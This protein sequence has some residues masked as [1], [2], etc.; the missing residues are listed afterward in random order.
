MM[1]R[2][3][4][5]LAFAA[6]PAFADD[7]DAAALQLAD[8]VQAEPVQASDW[9][10]FVEIAGG[11]STLRNGTQGGGHADNQRLSL[12]V[13]LD[14]RLARAWRL[15]FADRLDMN[16]HNEPVR[17][18][19]I[20]TLK[21]AYLGWQARDDLLFDLGRINVRNGVA[22][23]YNPTDYFRAGAVRS[24]VS[25]DPGSLKRNR[26]GSV[27]LRAQ[28]LWDSGSLSAAY[29]PKLS[30]HGSDAALNPNVG[31]TNNRDRWL[32]TFSQKLSKNVSPQW[33]L[34]K[35]ERQPVQAGFNLALLA[36]DATVVFM[37]WSGGRS[38]SL[39]SQA[40]A[41]ADDTAFR[42]RAST[43][44]TYTTP[45]KLSLTLEYEYNGAG[46]RDS[47]WNVLPRTS[48][49]AYGLYRAA[50]Q[51][52]QDMPTRNAVFF[53]AS[54]QDAMINHLDLSG[55]ERYNVADG[56][57]LSWLEARYHWDRWDA[58]LQWQMN[59]GGVTTEFG[60]SPQRRTVQAL[61]RYFF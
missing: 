59:S 15:V 14:T 53:Y 42:N 52:A 41:G 2:F 55:M 13:A 16:W 19:G 51:N 31:A 38:R 7:S 47:Q 21:E 60:A 28:T 4:L 46:L 34:Y 25:A 44:L 26:Q 29:S 10:A 24:V 17:Q 9:S 30:D 20:N 61:L 22:T 6:A 8:Q 56:S 54:W 43:G 27:M 37:E 32:F 50:L 3:A 18:D 1:R 57:R 48:L 40:T 12:D 11:R 35:E 45:G 39:F 58:A 36:N 33:L 23:G 5:L 49:P